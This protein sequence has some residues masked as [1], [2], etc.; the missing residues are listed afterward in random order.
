M[1]Y[2][3]AHVTSAGGHENAIKEAEKYGINSIQTMPTPPMRWALKDISEEQIEAFVTEQKKSGVKKLLL[4]G[5]Y[6]I[7]LARADKQMFH[8]GKMSIVTYLKYAQEVAK[9]AETLEVLGVT[10]HPGSAKDLTPEDGIKRIQYGLNWILEQVPGKGMLLLESSAGSGNIMGDTLEELASMRDGVEDKKRVGY[11]LDTQHMF[12][13]GYDWVKD[14]ENIVKRIDEYLGL[15]NVKC[16]HLNDSMV[17]LNSHKDRHDNLGKG[18]IGK[19]AIKAIVNHPKLNDIPFILETP[20]LKAD[21][22]RGVEI[23]NLRAIIG[24]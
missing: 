19:E 5:I 12:A 10:F 1:R 9:R 15:E 18:K 24:E 22:T 16:F 13:S 17:E 3:G 14:L 4:H 2:F 7:N 20:G 21:S 6:L 8:L 11:V 23:E